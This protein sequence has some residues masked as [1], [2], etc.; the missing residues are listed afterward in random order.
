MYNQ[1]MPE[2]F[3]QFNERRLKLVSKKYM[4]VDGLDIKEEAELLR[5]EG[6]VKDMLE[7]IWP[8]KHHSLA[9]LQKVADEEAGK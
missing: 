1:K 8:F 5:L 2:K 9:D 7:E 3:H 6:E 4:D